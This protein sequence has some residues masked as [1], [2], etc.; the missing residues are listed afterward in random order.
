M[1]YYLNPILIY[2]QITQT[3]SLLGKDI[4]IPMSKV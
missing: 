1:N 3:H 2:N 4:I